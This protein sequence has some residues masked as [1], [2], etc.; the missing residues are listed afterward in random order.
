MLEGTLVQSRSFCESLLLSASSG[1]EEREAI[2]RVRVL[3]AEVSTV[4]VL[5]VEKKKLENCVSGTVNC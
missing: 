2:E 1:H 4:F 5:P 3:G